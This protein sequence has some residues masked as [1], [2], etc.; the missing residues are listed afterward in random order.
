V[1]NRFVGKTVLVTG[2]GAGL[3][4]A[5]AQAFA[6]EGASVAV[7]GR[8]LEPL[9]ETVE[10]LGRK[11]SAIVADV[12]SPADVEAAVASIV[13]QHGSLDVAFNNAGIV[14]PPTPVAEIDAADWDATLST[15]LTGL[16]LCMKQ[17]I[18]H[19]RANGGGVIVNMASNIGPHVR[20]P[21]FGAY[22]ATKAGVSALTRTAAR[23]YIADGIRINAISPGAADTE[24]SRRPGESDADRDA[25]V[26][27]AVPLGRVG[28]TAEVAAAVLW[29]ASAEAAF[30]VGHDLVLDGGAT[31]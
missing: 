28:S 11:G 1:A 15:N 16:W 18:G 12:T 10:L 24:R 31:A 2:G 3:G 6:A 5:T 14:A 4:R 29:L 23:E 7:L 21:G 17:E 19:M 9:R 20:R 8:N 25:R 30:A 13:E 26:A 22:A 27:T